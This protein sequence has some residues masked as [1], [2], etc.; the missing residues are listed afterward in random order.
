MTI[1]GMQVAIVIIMK[2]VAWF[3][4]HMTVTVVSI[5]TNLHQQIILINL[6]GSFTVCTVQNHDPSHDCQH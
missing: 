2:L 3:S 6:L 5:G 4:I 1:V